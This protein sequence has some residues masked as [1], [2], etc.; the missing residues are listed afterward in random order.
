MLEKIHFSHAV[1]GAQKAYRSKI[2]W[3]GQHDVVF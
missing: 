3:K 1:T 2:D